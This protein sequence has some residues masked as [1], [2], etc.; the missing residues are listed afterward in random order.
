[1]YL[2]M[3]SMRQEAL[4]NAYQLISIRVVCTTI[5]TRCIIA[6]VLSVHS[7]SVFV[8]LWSSMWILRLPFWLGYA[9]CSF[10]IPDAKM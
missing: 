2:N 4:V 9:V 8:M 6:F 10:Y 3:V 5:F 1:M 7:I